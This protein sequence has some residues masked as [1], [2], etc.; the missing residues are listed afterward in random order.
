MPERR[1]PDWP[2][3]MGEQLAA[4]YL[5]LSVGTFRAQVMGQVTRVAITERRIVYLKEDLDAWLD[6]KAGKADATSQRSWEDILGN[7]P[8]EPAVSANRPGAG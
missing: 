1:L 4:A 3:A 6:R 2:R 7:G 5:D 8:G